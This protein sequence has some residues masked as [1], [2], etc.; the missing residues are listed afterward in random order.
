MPQKPQAR[1]RDKKRLTKR[2]A[3]WRKKQEAAGATQAS[4]PKTA[5]KG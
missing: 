4:A 3:N 5:T 1:A 2:L